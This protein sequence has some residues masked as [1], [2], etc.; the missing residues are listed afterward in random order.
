VRE[1][2]NRKDLTL[3]DTHFAFGKNWA[4]YAKRV[5]EVEVDEAVK[6]LARL[7]GGH[8]LGGKRV[9][10]I[11]CGSGLHSLAALKLGAREIVAIDI[12]PISVLTTQALLQRYAAES[13]FRIF[14]TSVF[15]LHSDDFGFF[16]LVYSWGVLHHTGDMYRAIRRAARMLNAHGEFV[17]ALYHRTLMCPVWVL[18]K[19]WYS[20]A[21]RTGQS[22]VRAMY[23]ALQVLRL[24]AKGRR[25]RDFVDDYHKSRGMSYYNDIHDW[26]GGYPYE[27]ILPD[28]VERLMIELG[29]FRVRCFVREGFGARIGL[30][31]TGCDEYVYRSNFGAQQYCLKSESE[32]TT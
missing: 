26:L 31:G 8:N 32:V 9:L 13:N 6:S 25:Y 2:A 16:D 19:K 17:F 18:E 30:F 5:S 12:D 24:W 20:K 27:S 7:L 14:K 22:A 29:F 10:D 28:D 11:G 1:L 3:I 23:I 15:D 4:D 21:S